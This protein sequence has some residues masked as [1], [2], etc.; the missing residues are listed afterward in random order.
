MILYKKEP[1]PLQMK[2]IMLIDDPTTGGCV[3]LSKQTYDQ[4]IILH[5]RLDGDPKRVLSLLMGPKFMNYGS[6]PGMTKALNFAMENMPEP[7]NCLAPFLLYCIDNKGIDW[8]NLTIETVYGILH[9][10]S[11]LVDFNAITLVPVEVRANMSL[12]TAIVLQYEAAWDDLC[13]SLK[14]KVVMTTAKNVKVEKETTTKVSP[15]KETSVPA[16]APVEEDEDEEE[17]DG[18]DWDALNAKLEAIKNAPASNGTVPE[19]KPTATSSAPAPTV[20]TPAPAPA[21]DDLVQK[22]SEAA[23]ANAVLNEFNY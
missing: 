23:A 7:I 14:D 12:P 9:M 17:D 18:I 13:S 15:K 16:P 21:N 20:H 8:E 5:N 4:A 6:V 11:Q 2:N 19:S 10:F 3:Y 1:F 22:K